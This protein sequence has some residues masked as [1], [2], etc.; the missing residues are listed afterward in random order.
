MLQKNDQRIINTKIFNTKNNE[1]PLLSF[2]KWD[3]LNGIKHCF[4]T[5]AGGVS[6]GYLSSLNLGWDRGDDKTNVT[7]N[8][9]RVAAAFGKG[10]ERLVLAKQTHTANVRIVTEEDAGK[11]VTADRDYDDVDGLVTNVPGL[12]LMTSHAD[13]VPLYFYDPVNKVIALAHAGWKG[14]LNKIGQ[15]TVNI[16][17][18]SFGSDPSDIYAA[19]GPSICQDC[20]EVSE[21]VADN[22]RSAGFCDVLIDGKSK[23][24]YQL[25]LWK[26]NEQVLLSSGITAD[27]ITVTNICTCCNPDTLFSHRA[28]Q[29]KRGNLGAFLM[30]E[31]G[32]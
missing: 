28:T 9:T 16:M 26:A 30:L 21:D 29:G 8:Y 32:I 18:D 3:S 24:K 17:S 2:E 12:I 15:N 1:L 22:F 27:H 11:G 13:C 4:T 31:D 19:I 14:T 23:G 7:E 25:D 10:P 20:Y 5:R 6:S